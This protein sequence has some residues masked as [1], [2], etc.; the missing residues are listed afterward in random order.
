SPTRPRPPA[1]RTNSARSAGSGAAPEP[2]AIGVGSRSPSRSGDSP[3]VPA[4]ALASRGDAMQDHRE[5]W[6]LHHRP[7]AQEDAMEERAAPPRGHVGHPIATEQKK[8]TFS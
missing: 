8:R 4:L 6:D 2:R 5:E 3:R 7:V 1:A